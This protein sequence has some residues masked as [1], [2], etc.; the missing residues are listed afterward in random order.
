MLLTLPGCMCTAGTDHLAV[1]KAT[2][3]QESTKGWPD[4]L[5]WE[6]KVQGQGQ[7]Q[8]LEFGYGLGLGSE[9]VYAPAA[10]QFSCT[11]RMDWALH[12][13]PLHA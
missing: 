6:C 7:G 2:H 13:W 12:F 10:A 4:H 9:S 8:G 3:S 11:N 5:T 1:P